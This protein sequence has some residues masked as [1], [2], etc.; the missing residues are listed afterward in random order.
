M[1]NSTFRIEDLDIDVEALIPIL[2]EYWLGHEDYELNP[3]AF[4]RVSKRDKNIMFCCPFHADRNPSSA[5]MVN[6]PYIFNCFSCGGF[7]LTALVARAIDMPEPLAEKF[8]KETFY[9]EKETKRPGILEKLEQQRNKSKKNF[10]NVQDLSGQNPEDSVKYFMDRLYL[11]SYMYGRGFSD[12]T[13]QKYEIGYDERLGTITFPV[14]DTEGDLRFIKRRYVQQKKFLNERGVNKKDLVYGLNYLTNRN[15][16]EIFLTESETD[17]MACY[18][19]GL[20]AGAT[21]GKV[22]FKEQVYELA[23]E[24]FNTINLFYDNDEA[25]RDGIHKAYKLIRR[26]SPIR[27]NVVLYPN[28]L[29]KDANDLLKANLLG[30]IQTVSYLQFALSEDKERGKFCG[31]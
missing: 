15:Y 22:L 17:T 2:R 1:T 27:V 3:G 4:T 11:T 28:S 20:V 5:L 21:L 26:I 23:K 18:Q 19:Y 30:K 31:D 9:I 12:H 29:L 25:G 16:K 24:G 10:K 7:S 8:L 13:L 14:R 6:P